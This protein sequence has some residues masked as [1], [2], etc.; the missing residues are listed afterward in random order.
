MGYKFVTF[1]RGTPEYL[2]TDAEKY[3]ATRPSAVIVDMRYAGAAVG[4]SLL[5]CYRE[6]KNPYESA[7]HNPDGSEKGKR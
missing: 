3:F 1:T 5:V 7:T 4:F 6:I 2:A